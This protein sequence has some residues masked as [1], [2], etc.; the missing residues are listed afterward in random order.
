MTFPTFK[1]KLM[2][3]LKL[4]RTFIKTS[5]M[6]ANDWPHVII[7]EKDSNKLIKQTF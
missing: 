7:I 3:I 2:K 5:E 6:A 1:Q 4:R